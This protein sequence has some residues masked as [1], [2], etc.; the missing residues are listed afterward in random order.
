MPFFIDV[1]CLEMFPERGSRDQTHTMNR[2][3]RPDQGEIK[4]KSE[5]YL[6]CF[7][8][9]WHTEAPPCVH[10]NKNN[11]TC[12]GQNGA[13]WCNTRISIHSEMASF[14][15]FSEEGTIPAQTWMLCGL[16][17]LAQEWIREHHIMHYLCHYSSMATFELAY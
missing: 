17:E 15:C 7:F 10:S 12:I 1:M 11:L 8:L 4:I 3:I 9:P 16:Q 5:N 13:A 6:Q 14:T 2:K